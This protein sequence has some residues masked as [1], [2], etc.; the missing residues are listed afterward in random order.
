MA[1]EAGPSKK[2]QKTY[3]F[4]QAWEN[5]FLFTDIKDKCICLICGVGDA[6]RKK[7]NVERHF[8]MVHKEFEKN[9]PAGSSL[10]IKEA[11]KLKVALQRPQSFLTKPVKKANMATEASF[12]IV[13]FLT[14]NMAAFSGGV[15][16][17]ANTM[18]KMV[19][20]LSADILEQLARDLSTF[21]C[22]ESDDSTKTAQLAVFVRIG[23]EG[24]T[25][26]EEYLIL[27]T[28]KATTR[29]VDIYE[30]KILFCKKECDNQ[31]AIHSK[32]MGFDHVMTPVV[33]IIN[34]IHART[35]QHHQFKLLLDKPSS[36][37]GNLLLHTETQWL[38]R[39]K[40]L[41]RF[42]PLVSE[43]KA[44][45]E[46]RNESTTQISDSAWL[47]DLAFLTDM[48]KKLNSLNCELQEKQKNNCQHD[49]HSESFQIETG[50]LGIT[51]A[52]SQNAALSSKNCSKGVQEQN[53]FQF[54]DKICDFKQLEPCVK[55]TSNPLIKVDIQLKSRYPASDFL[56]L[57]DTERYSNIRAAAMKVA[58]LFGST[59]LCESIFS[60]M[61]FIK[62]KFQI[63]LTYKHLNDSIRVTLSS[64]KPN[65]T[66]L[67][68]NQNRILN[69][70]PPY[71]EVGVV[72]GDFQQRLNEDQTAVKVDKEKRRLGRDCRSW[73]H[74][75]QIILILNPSR[76]TFELNGFFCY[77]RGVKW[78]H[79]RPSRDNKLTGL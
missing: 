10:C 34:L 37:Y 53:L 47:L 8:A 23:F 59:Y 26:K 63:Q 36:E 54:T 52:E 67:N 20:A 33:K 42:L 32:V 25:I 56:S 28:L 29:G 48:T 58:S 21:Q 2:R 62:S 75:N 30:V 15:M 39:G 45:M 7:S 27:L 44:F 14:K 77:K 66:G 16:S 17:G 4:H 68:G 57:V 76:D 50:P 43:I 12:E 22:D 69:F 18:A 72:G 6:I 79:P 9:F 51:V 1:A 40:V 71:I 38:S 13:H 41:C 65:F 70:E 11:S 74:H 61:N 60:D 46:S 35:L 31:E 19:L 5:D 24:F 78:K 55:F 3:Y 73:K 64:Y 49:K